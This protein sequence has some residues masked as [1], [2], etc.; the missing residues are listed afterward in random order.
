MSFDWLTAAGFLAF[1]G[2]VGVLIYV[3]STGGCGK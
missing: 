1:F 2:I 3:C